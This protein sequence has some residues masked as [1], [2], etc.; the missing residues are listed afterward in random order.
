MAKLSTE[1]QR[2]ARAAAAGRLSLG[3]GERKQAGLAEKAQEARAKG[4]QEDSTYR[5]LTRYKA[6]M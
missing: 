4:G 2:S 3:L 6:G 5:L 1:W